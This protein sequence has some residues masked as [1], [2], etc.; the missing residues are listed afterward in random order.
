MRRGILG[1]QR[2]ARRLCVR[3]AG[4]SCRHAAALKDAKYG[5]YIPVNGV[6]ELS[7]SG[8]IVKGGKKH[9]RTSKW[10]VSC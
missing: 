6:V 2:H 1:L 10:K 4:E 8:Y 9:W 3:V 7:T 5:Y